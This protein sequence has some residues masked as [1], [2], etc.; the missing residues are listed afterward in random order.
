MRSDSPRRG[1]DAEAFEVL[2]SRYARALYPAALKVL[3]NAEDTE[4]ALQEGLLAAFRNLRHFEGRSQFSTWL[5]PIVINAA[6]MRLRSR[7]ARPVAS[8]DDSPGGQSELTFADLLA[9]P[10]LN[11]EDACTQ[12]EMDQ[13]F[14]EGVDTLADKF[15]SPV[16]L[17]DV[18]GF[19]TEEAAQVL[20]ISEGTL[21]SRLHRARAS[22][23]SAVRRRPLPASR[24]R[25]VPPAELAPD[26]A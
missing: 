13:I 20:H 25:Y 8:P 10:G 17:R 23:A 5:T 3:G 22:L 12:Q 26:V 9:D 11:P 2:F 1:G 18:E 6:L 19:S 7:R 4:D 14:K 16:V 21:K 15:R 24:S